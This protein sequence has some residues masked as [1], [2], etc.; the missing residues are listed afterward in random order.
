MVC[1]LEYVGCLRR[2]PVKSGFNHRKMRREPRDGKLRLALGRSLNET[3]RVSPA[4]EK[5]IIRRHDGLLDESGWCGGTDDKARRNRKAPVQMR[6]LPA[7]RRGI[8]AQ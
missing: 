8:E 2:S 4:A 5:N 6:G 1:G 3:R 7:G